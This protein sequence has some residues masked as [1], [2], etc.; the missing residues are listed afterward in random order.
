[1][2]GFACKLIKDSTEING[3]SARSTSRQYNTRTVTQKWLLAQTPRDAEERLWSILRHNVASFQLLIDYVAQL[4]AER[5]MVRLSSDVLPLYTACGRWFYDKPEVEQYMITEFGRAGQTARDMGV[6]LSMHPGQYTVLAS[7][8][9]NIVNRSIEEFEY[10]A[11]VAELLGYG[12]K[13]QDFKINIHV[14]GRLGAQGM[15]LAYNRLT[16]SAKNTITIENTE[17]GDNSSWLE[18][19]EIAP[20]VLDVHHWWINTNEYI[21]V[22]SDEINQVIASWRGIR[23]VIHYSQSRR[24]VVV[25]A[26]DDELLDIK[27]LG[28]P[29]TR[30][31]AH[32]DF[33]WNHA[34]NA[35]AMMFAPIAD[36]MCESKAKNLAVDELLRLNPI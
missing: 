6:R 7:E 5:R 1:M 29:T 15:K 24:D 32:S 13:F 35:W 27:Q 26:A 30:L 19:A 9:A 14:S 36:I 16:D 21:A 4:P 33:Y 10:H 31:R 12:K 17:Y 23:P 20:L 8:N 11:R 2:F 22:D 3:I 25:D 28:I 34:I 18:L